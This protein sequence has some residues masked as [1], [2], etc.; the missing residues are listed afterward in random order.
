MNGLQMFFQA[1]NIVVRLIPP[2]KRPKA[3]YSELL[4]ALPTIQ[5]NTPP[6]IEIP[7]VTK[8]PVAIQEESA[9]TNR[10]PVSTSCLSCSRSHLVTIAG[11]LGESLRF[12]RDGGIMDPEVVRRLD[13]AEKEVNIMERIDLSP[14]AIQNS[15]EKEQKLAHQFLPKIRALRQDIGQVASVDQLEKTAAE[16]N[17]LSQEFR[18]SQ[19]MLNG[20]DINPILE[21]ARKV[22]SGEMTMDE[23]R[24]KVKEYLPGE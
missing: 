17:V 24:M 9:N 23:A 10:A 5:I 15:P 3:D 8:Q 7:E 2:P 20:T 11:A 12:A 19:M 21:L 6:P 14:E 16:A 18:L 22:K 1:A 13:I 4:N